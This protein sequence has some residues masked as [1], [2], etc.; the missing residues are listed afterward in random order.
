ML[1]PPLGLFEYYKTQFEDITRYAEL[2]TDVFPAFRELGN[3]ILFCMHIEQS[4]VGA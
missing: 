2:R 1:L 3:I 4:L